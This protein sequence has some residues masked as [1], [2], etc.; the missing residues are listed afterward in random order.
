PSWSCVMPGG[1][2]SGRS[3]RFPAVTRPP[4]G[5]T[6][7]LSRLKPDVQIAG[8]KKVA[9]QRILMRFC[10]GDAARHVRI[11]PSKNEIKRSLAFDVQAHE[12]S[13]LAL[14]RGKNSVPCASST[15]L[16]RFLA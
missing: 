4:A 7:F 1:A 10:R 15:G 11:P 12:V 6:A 14:R 3:R 8:L 2:S 9:G 13:L 16:T 5:Y